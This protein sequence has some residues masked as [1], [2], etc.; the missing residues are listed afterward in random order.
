MS[1]Q[2]FFEQGNTYPKLLGDLI[3][4]LKTLD[5]D[6]LGNLL[7]IARKMVKG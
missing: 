1:P 6:V 3:S 7:G 5:E 2:E 4:V